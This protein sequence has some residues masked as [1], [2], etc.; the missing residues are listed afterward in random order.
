MG[1]RK[2]R[3][4]AGIR[5]HSAHP[6]ADFLDVGFLDGF[7]RRKPPFGDHRDPVANFEQ[8]VEFLG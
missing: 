7:G 3:F 6:D 8:F 5:P 1:R 2:M 4:V